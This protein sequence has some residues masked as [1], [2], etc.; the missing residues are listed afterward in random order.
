MKMPT[1][2][3][4]SS[5][6]SSSPKI[7][8]A[9]YA[10]TACIYIIFVSI[11]ARFLRVRSNTI[12]NS[13]LRFQICDWFWR[14]GSPH[15]AQPVPT[16]TIKGIVVGGRS[17]CCWNGT[18]E[19]LLS[20]PPCPSPPLSSPPQLLNEAANLTDHP[21]RAG[22]APIDYQSCVACFC[23][24]ALGSAPLPYREARVTCICNLDRYLPTYTLDVT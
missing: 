13:T 23:R 22:P 19:A 11:P 20:S 15:H 4:P 24:S 6:I 14:E 16:G 7:S 21:P 9:S 8:V 5:R 10:L 12:W 2:E 17:R 3:H 1:T 18:E